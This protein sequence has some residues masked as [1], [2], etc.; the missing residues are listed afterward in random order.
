MTY[1]LYWL[2]LVI[3]IQ[4]YYYYILLVNIILLLLAIKAII[5]EELRDIL[6][7]YY[8]CYVGYY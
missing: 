6:D 3:I 1:I 7:I 8:Y 4:Y 2:L 5:R